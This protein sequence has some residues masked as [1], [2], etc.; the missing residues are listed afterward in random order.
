MKNKVLFGNMFRIFLFF[1]LTILW[2]YIVLLFKQYSYYTSAQKFYKQNHLR[3]AVDNYVMVV[4]MHTPLSL[5]ESHSISKLLKIAEL[6]EKNN[7]KLL[8]FYTL[9]RLRSALYGT[10]WLA[11]PHKNI[12]KK[13]ESKLIILEANMLKKDGYKKSLK[14]TKK[15]LSKIMKT[16]LAPNPFLSLAGIFSF[17]LFF[18]FIILG[19]LK[20][21]SNNRFD[22]KKFGVYFLA[23]IIFWLIWLTCMYMA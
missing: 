2:I 21:S 23:S 22:Y 13:V 11:T 8:E 20:S 12:L 19:I 15:E 16:D 10:R 4:Y 3:K 18:S 5:F 6:S 17:I 14:N 1:I 9:E 7:K